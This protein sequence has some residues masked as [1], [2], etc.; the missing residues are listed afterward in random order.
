MSLI[1]TNLEVH[2]KEM[3]VSPAENNA[4]Y[5]FHWYHRIKP[6]LVYSGSNSGLLQTLFHTLPAA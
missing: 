2:T 5:P 1:T 4:K 3:E 6:W